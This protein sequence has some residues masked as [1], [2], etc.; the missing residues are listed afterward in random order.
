[1]HIKVV[2]F[3]KSYFIT[4]SG[5]FILFALFWEKTSEFATSALKLKVNKPQLP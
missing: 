5:E 2:S 3:Q 4:N 1:M